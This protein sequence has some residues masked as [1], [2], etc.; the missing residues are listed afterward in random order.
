MS[1]LLSPELQ[2]LIAEK[3]RSGRYHSADELIREGLALLQTKEEQAGAEDSRG[4]RPI[5][6]VFAV[7]AR[8]VPEGE[9][10][11]IPSDLSRNLDHYLYGS[12]KPD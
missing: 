4:T 12:P 10:A 7:I 9:W 8:D 11:K 5:A 3:L 1:I 6:E 2:R